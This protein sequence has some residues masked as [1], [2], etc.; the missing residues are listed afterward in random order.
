MLIIIMGTITMLYLSIMLGL[1]FKTTQYSCFD[2][3]RKLVFLSPLIAILGLFQYLFDKQ[4]NLGSKIFTIVHFDLFIF[5][6]T[7]MMAESTIPEEMKKNRKNTMDFS[8]SFK[9][10]I[11]NRRKIYCTVLNSMESGKEMKIA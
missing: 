1:Y 11:L 6:T 9:N 5:F 2:G 3:K 7:Y 8:K 10:I 4:F